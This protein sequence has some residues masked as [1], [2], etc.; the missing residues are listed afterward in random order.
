MTPIESAQAKI[1]AEKMAIKQLGNEARDLVLR[2]IKEA[3]G[4]YRLHRQ[5]GMSRT[6]ILSWSRGKSVPNEESLKRLR[7]WV[8][9]EA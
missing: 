1:E 7:Q 3:G 8:G 5:S 2:A 6:S 4:Q 9:E